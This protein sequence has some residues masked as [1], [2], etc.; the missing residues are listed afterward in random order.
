MEQKKVERKDPLQS[1]NI[2]ERMQ[3]ILRSHG[4]DEDIVSMLPLLPDFRP[5]RMS[6][7]KDILVSLRPLRTRVWEARFEELHTR[8]QIDELTASKELQDYKDKWIDHMIRMTEVWSRERYLIPGSVIALGKYLN[9]SA[10]V[11]SYLS[12]DEGEVSLK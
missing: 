7:E 9:D 1:S 4:V 10:S 8:K 6:V 5:R 11:D 2:S 3:S 12:V